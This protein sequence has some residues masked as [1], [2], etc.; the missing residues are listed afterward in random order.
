V[1]EIDHVIFFV[2]G[3]DAVDLTGFAVEPGREHTGQGTRN[4]RVVFEDNYFELAW[5]EHPEQ[6][7]ARGLDFVGRCARPATACPF[8]CVLRGVIPAE[9]RARFVRY[10]LP[11]APGVALQMLADQRPHAPF[12]AV[13]EHADGARP[14]W[15]I[16][17][18]YLAHANGAKRIVRALFTV[19][20]PPPCPELAA[21][22]FRVGAPSLELDL[23]GIVVTF[24]P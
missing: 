14:A 16:A 6:V 24:R 8:G 9:L 18:E 23:G 21:L 10:E 3:R 11:D 7:V 1:L 2:P 13:F 22:E 4:V 5:V 19:P 12:L 15:R 17:P 20:E